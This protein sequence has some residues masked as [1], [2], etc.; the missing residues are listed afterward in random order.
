MNKAAYRD[1][2][3]K[4]WLQGV[5]PVLATLFL[6]AQFI[7]SVHAATYG[8]TGHTHDGQPCIIAAVCKKTTDFDIVPSPILIVPEAYDVDFACINC[9]PEFTNAPSF[10]AIRAPPVGSL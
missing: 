6:L 1:E 4:L 5:I 3:K 2:I 10:L 9:T 8:D 7:S